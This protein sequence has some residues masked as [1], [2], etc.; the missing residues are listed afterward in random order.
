[1]SSGKTF[2]HKGH[3]GTLLKSRAYREISITAK[4]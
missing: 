3:E 2:N 1:V 4:I